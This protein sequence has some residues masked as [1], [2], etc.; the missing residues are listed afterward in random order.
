MATRVALPKSE[1]DPTAP[2]SPYAVAKLAGEHVLCRVQQC[3]WPGN[4]AAALFQRLRSAAVAG[5]SVCGGDPAVHAG[6]G[7]GQSAA[8]STAT[9]G[10]RATS[11]TSPTWSR[12]TCWP[13]RRRASAAGCTTSPAA[14]GR[15][16]WNWSA[17]SEC[18]ARHGRSSRSTAPRPGDVRHSQ[19]DIA[20]AQADLGYAPQMDIETGLARCL[21][22]HQG[23]VEQE[24]E[25]AA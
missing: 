6:A 24:E 17:A 12:P 1:T 3:L 10:N 8:R 11:P 14:G 19:A 15:R 7:R 25:V 4:G 23:R 13:P 5:Q 22:W 2:L 21:E 16:C 9:A 20:R 18:A